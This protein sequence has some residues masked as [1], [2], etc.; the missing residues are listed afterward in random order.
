MI[1][2]MGS[3]HT[4]KR[5]VTSSV[6]ASFNAIGPIFRCTAGSRLTELTHEPVDI[7]ALM[8][9]YAAKLAPALTGNRNR[10]SLAGEPRRITIDAEVLR[11]IVDNLLSNACKFTVDGDIQLSWRHENATTIIQVRDS[12]CGIPPDYHQSIFEPFWQA[13]MSLTREHGGHG[14]GLSI[15]KRFI[16]LLGG[17]I[18]VFSDPGAGALFTVKIPW[19]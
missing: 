12:G 17:T 18:S 7:Q 15:T 6:N 16:E 5:G 13:D 8:E 2:L 3:C 11:H 10:L 1:R 9:Q 14:L 19:Q 4:T